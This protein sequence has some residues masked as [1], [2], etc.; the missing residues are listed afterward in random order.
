M[1]NTLEIINDFIKDLVEHG[2]TEDSV[3]ELKLSSQTY[4]RFVI[5]NGQDPDRGNIVTF[6][7]Q[8][9]QIVIKKDVQD[10]IDDKLYKIK[11][12]QADIDLL[13]GDL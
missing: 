4:S 3:R 13:K 1:K 12:L 10:E 11:C 5:E 7:T 8:M 9:G 6:Y 2:H